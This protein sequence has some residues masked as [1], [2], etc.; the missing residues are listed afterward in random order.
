MSVV[1]Y[2]LRTLWRDLVSLFLMVFAIGYFIDRYCLRLVSSITN[3][4]T[5]RCLVLTTTILLL[6]TFGSG[7]GFND[8][9]KVI[10]EKN[11]PA[12]RHEG[13]FSVYEYEFKGEGRQHTKDEIE[14]Y[15]MSPTYVNR[16]L[17]DLV[18]HI[19]WPEQQSGLT[20][21]AL[22]K[23]R[24]I[25]LW[26][27]IGL[28][29]PNSYI[30]I[31]TFGETEEELKTRIRRLRAKKGESW[32]DSEYGLSVTDYSYLASDAL[33]LET[34]RKMP[35]DDGRITTQT[36][37]KAL[38][39][40][41]RCAQDGYICKLSGDTHCC[42][43]WTFISDLRLDW[44]FGITAKDNAEWYEKPVLCFS[45]DGY[46]NGGGTGTSYFL[47]KVFSLPDGRELFVEDYFAVDKLKELSNY[48]WQ[49]FLE[50]WNF[51]DA[52]KVDALKESKINLLDES[53]SIVPSKEGMKWIWG[54]DTLCPRNDG[55]PAVFTTWKEL[56]AFRK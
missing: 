33:S 42:Q 22:A 36:L 53:I 4:V 9:K 55:T 3:F 34:G 19:E 32:E 47:A 41:K 16:S 46:I 24:R 11:E 18:W 44:P 17:I 6:S 48:V 27:T 2:V 29:T 39:G 7:C 23:V 31:E 30:P 1:L 10:K 49:K 54:Y 21:D 15:G 8:G 56:Q 51:E 28:E 12:S 14:K 25:I 52:E 43:N 26:A 13:R 38:S 37:E 40:L 20:P 50:E 5:L 45:S 35:K